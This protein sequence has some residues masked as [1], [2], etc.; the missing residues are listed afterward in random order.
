MLQIYVFPNFEKHT[1]VKLF[2]PIQGSSLVK[3]TF[4]KEKT[5]L[6]RNANISTSSIDFQQIAWVDDFKQITR[7]YLQEIFSITYDLLKIFFG[8]KKIDNWIAKWI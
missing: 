8:I 6:D 4:W 2:P 1:I 7:P 3:T 5:I